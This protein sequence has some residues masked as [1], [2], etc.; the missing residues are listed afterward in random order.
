MP[1]YVWFETVEEEAISK[2]DSPYKILTNH[3]RYTVLLT[4]IRFNKS[5]HKPA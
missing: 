1:Q 2:D 3:G 4:H 5:K